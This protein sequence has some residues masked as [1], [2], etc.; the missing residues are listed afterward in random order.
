MP[1]QAEL[2]V[3]P[4]EVMGKANK[5]LRRTGII[6]G[7]ISGHNQPPQAVQIDAVEFER[8]RRK[9]AATSIIALK[10]P[11]ATQTALIRHVQHNP[12]SG[13]IVHI[14]FSRVSLTE[15]IT[16][17]ITLRYI[18]E[19]PAV[20][21]EGGVL[22]HLLDT[23]EVACLASDIADHIDVDITSLTE[24]DSML[25]AGD[26]KLPENYTLL[27]EATEPI[28][29]IGATRA[30]VTTTETAAPAAPETPAAE[31]TSEA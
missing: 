23:I 3:A 2:N 25:H 7:N 11:D 27:T 14:D 18:G 1:E 5:K 6:P 21:N 13:K 9:G 8:L 4:R 22:L 29:K 28:A 17:N 19:S 12:R 24:I 30:E 16:M 15:R 26:V 20:K 10:L 31:P